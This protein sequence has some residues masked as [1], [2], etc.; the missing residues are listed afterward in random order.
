MR[1][2]IVF[3]LAAGFLGPGADRV[4]AQTDFSGTWALD[5][6]ISGDLSKASFEPQ[7]QSQTRRNAG[8]FSGG[9][10][11]RGFGGRNASGGRRSNGADGGGR[12][13]TSLTEEEKA[14]L[15]DLAAYVRGLASIVIE[16][17]DHST[18]TVTDAQKQSHLFPTDG[19]KTP[20]AF[21]TTTIDTV[22][23]WDGP[24]MVTAYTIGP[25]HDLLF[26]YILV[27]ATKQMA[28]RVQLDESG[29]A[30]ADVPEL[31][32][33]YKLKAAPAKAPS[34]PPH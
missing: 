7:Q 16:H 10:G 6:E 28:L 29:R 9:F 15:R 3:M 11:G 14:R 24:H 34:V 30:R 13:G 19:S 27:P 21:A 18:F 32:L 1:P 25:S 33:V 17:T 22:T 20:Q 23:K 8:G 26:T 4:F 31:K 5:R 12:N 2:L